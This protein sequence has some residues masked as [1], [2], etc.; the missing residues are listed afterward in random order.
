M[1][2]ILLIVTLITLLI[3]TFANV[4][5]WSKL[6]IKE[7]NIAYGLF[8]LMFLVFFTLVLGVIIC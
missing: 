2:Q 5:L 8:A 4:V 7:K 3:L 6:A 1:E